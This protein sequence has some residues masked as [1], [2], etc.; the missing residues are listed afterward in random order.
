MTSASRCA[1]NQEFKNY[2][3]TQLIFNNQFQLNEFDQRF[4]TIFEHNTPEL[5]TK[6]GDTLMQPSHKLCE[7]S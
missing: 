3:V 7:Y 5:A 6:S 4:F 1:R 2:P